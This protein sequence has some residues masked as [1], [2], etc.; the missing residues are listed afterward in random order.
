[1][2]LLISYGTPVAFEGF[3]T[4]GVLAACVGCQ[5]RSGGALANPAAVSLQESY[6]T[7]WERA[8]QRVDTFSLSTY[9]DFMSAGADIQ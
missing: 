2:P 9:L 5:D 7:R 1:M 6:G 3:G 8:K 4:D